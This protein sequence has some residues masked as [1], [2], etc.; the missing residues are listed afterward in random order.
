MIW[1]YD[2]SESTYSAVF[3]RSDVEIVVEGDI[4]GEADAAGAFL[5]LKEGCYYHYSLRDPAARLSEASSFIRKGKSRNHGTIAPGTAVGYGRFYL[6]GAESP[7]LALGVEVASEVISYKK[8]YQDLLRQLTEDIADLQMQCSSCVSGL[9][10]PDATAAA[11]NDVQRFFFLL[12]LIAN[13]EFDIALREI[14]RRPHVQLVE[15]ACEMDSRNLSRFGRNE[16]RQLASASRRIDLPARLRGKLSGLTSIPERIATTRRIESADTQEN[17]FIKYVLTFFLE[18]LQTFQRV[19]AGKK[20]EGSLMTVEIDLEAAKKMLSKWVG[21]EF[22]KGVGRLNQIPM[23][24]VVLQRR[25]GYREVFKKW[26]Q[27]HAGAQLVWENGPDVYEA[28]QRQMST[29]Y[30]YWC[31]FRLLKIVGSIFGVGTAEIAKKM[32]GTGADGLSLK[33][34]SGESITLDG[35]FDSGRVGARYRRLAIEFSYNRTFSAKGKEMSWT[36][37]MRPDYT[38]SFRP[39]GMT[40]RVA[41]ANDLVTYVHFD[42]KYK[43]ADLLSSLSQIG[44]EKDVE[45][46]QE[47]EARSARDVKRVDILKMHAYRDAIRRTGGAYVLFPGQNVDGEKIR[48]EN[49]EIIPGLGAFVMSPSQDSSD[50]IKGFLEDVARHLCD[51]I[52]RWE[53]YTYQTFEIY[54]QGRVDFEAD[55]KRTDNLLIQEYD[56]VELRDGHRVNLD[57]VASDRYFDPNR[58][59][60]VELEQAE[61]R[62]KWAFDENYFILEKS[63]WDKLNKPDPAIVSLISVAWHPPTNL[64]VQRY[65]G[66]MQGWMVNAK[67]PTCPLNFLNPKNRDA[68]YLIW[69]VCAI[70]TMALEKRLEISEKRKLGRAGDK[71]AQ[72]WLAARGLK[73]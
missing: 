14:V 13:P 12:G 47:E 3:P 35:T 5:P 60:S 50:R 40:P 67:Y 34:K 32:I 24:S 41:I 48:R 73:P 43:S 30:E 38:I 59:I 28:N 10:K 6:E 26:L 33:L 4:F 68:D 15:I 54:R 57:A 72:A 62:L 11:K 61:K 21:H 69:E 63:I 9:V 23:G 16:M 20:K 51:R 29:L 65:C 49:M 53:K 19:L 45:G 27:Y 25:E 8:D 52:T 1:R 22:F 36:L 2:S 39:M 37:P 55:R 56:D 70:D 46:S 71:N 42:A 31:F 64:I 7:E 44:G 18:Q 66:D 17:R 58:F